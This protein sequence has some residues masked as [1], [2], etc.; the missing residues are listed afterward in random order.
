MRAEFDPRVAYRAV[1]LALG[2]L[3]AGLLFEELVQIVMLVTI[4]VVIAVPLAASASWLRRW[5][6]P[7]PSARCWPSPAGATVAG[8]MLAFVVP[9]FVSSGQR[10]R[11]AA[12]DHGRALRADH[13]QRAGPQA[14]NDDE[15][16]DAVRQPLHAPSRRPAWSAG[17]HRGLDRH[18]RGS[19]R[20]GDHQRAVHGDQ[21]RSARQRAGAACFRRPGSPTSGARWS[22]SASP[23]WPGCAASLWTCSCS[24]ACSSW[25]CRSSGSSSRRASRSSRR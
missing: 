19:D 5:H 4:A 8:V 18:R 3:A 20:G 14:G 22:G 7:G 24:E 16:R 23:G 11:R 9:T 15:G 17:D 13:Q 25:A 1:L 6:V 2:L 12:A 10:L 21:P